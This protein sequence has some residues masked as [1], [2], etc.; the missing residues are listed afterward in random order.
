LKNNIVARAS[1]RND[2]L[3]QRFEEQWPGMNFLERRAVTLAYEHGKVQTKDLVTDEISQDAS[4]RVLRKL[5]QKGVLD[6]V[7]TSPTSPTRHY[8][9]S[10]N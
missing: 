4:R 6:V 2:L 1:R 8:I 5:V 10:D 3:Q 9:L 7:A